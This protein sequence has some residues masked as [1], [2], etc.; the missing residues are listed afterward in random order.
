MLYFFAKII[1]IIG[2]K[3]KKALF[4]FG[5]PLFLEVTEVLRTQ[6]QVPVSWAAVY[7]W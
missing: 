6:G 2:N 7:F 3:K 4:Y 5:N 1:N